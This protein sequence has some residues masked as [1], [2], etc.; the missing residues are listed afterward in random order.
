MTTQAI[1]FR[2]RQKGIVE[3]IEKSAVPF[4]FPHEH[5]RFIFS[6]LI[7]LHLVSPALASLSN[8]YLTPH[9]SKTGYGVG[10]SQSIG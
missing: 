10:L 2:S 7:L 1:A 4:S 5:W 6:S 8:T 9:L 3:G